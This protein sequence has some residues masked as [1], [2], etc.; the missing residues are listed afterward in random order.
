MIE[1]QKKMDLILNAVMLCWP[2]TTVDVD[3]IQQTNNVNTQ[4]IINKV[5]ILYKNIQFL[6]LN[7]PK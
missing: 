7:A 1:I 3:A 4:K 2:F 5:F 6:K